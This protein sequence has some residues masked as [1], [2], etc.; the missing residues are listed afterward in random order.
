GLEVR[1]CERPTSHVMSIH[2]SVLAGVRLEVSNPIESA[3]M[4]WGSS[5]ML[6]STW[7]KGTTTQDSRK[8]LAATESRA[9][10]IDGFAG[11]NSVGLQLTGLGK[12]WSAL[13]GIFTD[14]LL[15]PIFPKEEVDHARRTTE[16][17]VRN[18]ADHSSQLCSK[19][20]L[21][22]LFESHPYGRMT[23]G[24]LD[25]LPSIVQGKLSTF[26]RE[27]VRPE[28][29][30]ISISGPIKQSAMEN[31]VHHLEEKARD[32]KRHYQSNFPLNSPLALPAS[33]A[34]EPTLKA[35]RWIEKTLNREQ[36]HI[37]IGGLGTRISAEDRFPLRLLQT[38][39][40]GQ[41]GRLFIELREKKSL[42]YTVSPISFEGLEKG[43]V[44]TYIACSP[45]KRK[46]A[47]EGI[48]KTFE[49]LFEKGPSLKEMER[50]KEF[51]I[52]R[53][54]MDLQSDPSLAA[55]FGLEA[56]YKIPNLTEEQLAKKIRAISAKDLRA[57]CR[58]YFLEPHMV[59]SIVG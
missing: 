27:W 53:R 15:N 47:I 19:L 34:D 51:Y 45:E 22:T 43:Y 3:A 36:C 54:A 5:S 32:Q 57:I 6:A 41:S 59:T 33:L 8:I 23:H 2:A 56:L 58:K 14:V 24:S 17:S 21:E 42:A 29:L 1:F 55:H 26:H 46:E 13:S 48:R 18:V 49:D 38:L 40:G 35:P 12:D 31:W 9:A 20:F 16:E 28:R 52:G 39:L 37:M 4:D 30:V 10:S 7:T 44:G 50:A 25:S 11:R